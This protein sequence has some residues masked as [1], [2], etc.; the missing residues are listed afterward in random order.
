M[1]VVGKQCCKICCAYNPFSSLGGPENVLKRSREW[2]ES[3]GK[4]A[5]LGYMAV[6]AVMITGTHVSLETLLMVPKC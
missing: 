3:S 4:A 2:G 1:F 6:P 5:G